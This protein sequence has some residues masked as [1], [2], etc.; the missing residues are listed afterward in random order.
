MIYIVNRSEIF[1]VDY[2][3][4]CKAQRFFYVIRCFFCSQRHFDKLSIKYKLIK[5][6]NQKSLY[7]TF[8]L[9]PEN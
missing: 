2:Y 4:E 7:F 3:F 1:H 5:D 6:F 9:N 8:N